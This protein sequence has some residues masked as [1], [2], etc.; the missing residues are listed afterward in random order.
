M[1]ALGFL[2]FDRLLAYFREEKPD[3][4]S[5]RLAAGNGKRPSG[6]PICNRPESGLPSFRHGLWSLY[7]LFDGRLKAVVTDAPMTGVRV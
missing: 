2:A 6:L 4:K 3:T 1:D 7:V 5:A